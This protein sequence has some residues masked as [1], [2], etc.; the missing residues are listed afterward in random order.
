RAM[1]LARQQTKPMMIDFYADWC[2]PCKELDKFTFTDPLVIEKSRNFI[3]VKA[4]LTQ[5][6]GQTI[7]G[8]I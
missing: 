8:R 2:I 6:G 4:D 1:K 7:K 3:M 5:S